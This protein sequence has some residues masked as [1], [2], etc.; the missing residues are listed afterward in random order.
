MVGYLLLSCARILVHEKR[1]QSSQQDILLLAAAFATLLPK[2]CSWL[3][4]GKAIHI[5]Y[6]LGMLFPIIYVQLSND[7]GSAISVGQM[8]FVRL[9]FLPCGLPLF[10]VAFWNAA[11]FIGSVVRF[12]VVAAPYQ[13]EAAY[14]PHTLLALEIFLFTLT[15]AVSEWFRLLA[16]SEM[17]RDALAK[18]EGLQYDALGV[19]M[20]NVCDVTLPLDEHFV[21]SSDS[22]RFTALLMRDTRRSLKGTN[23]QDYMAC[24]DDKERFRNMFA[25]KDI[26]EKPVVACLNLSLRESSGINI[27]VEVFGVRFKRIDGVPSYIL[28]IRE[29]AA[30]RWLAPLRHAEETDTK[31]KQ[32]RSTRRSV[33]SG[34][35]QA[36]MVGVSPINQLVDDSQ[37]H[38][39]DSLFDSPCTSTSSK[40]KSVARPY[41]QPT[42]RGAKLQSMTELIAVWSVIAPNKACCGFHATLAEAKNVL[43]ILLRGP[44]QPAF[45][46][47]DLLQCGTCGILSDPKGSRQ[48]TLCECDLFA[49][50]QAL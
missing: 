5:S 16:W 6:G 17:F 12:A 49:S 1:V 2:H 28:G 24:E 47:E 48:C 39:F 30:D 13:G 37:S 9:S 27:G 35:P 18:S 26:G 43:K 11:C 22:K 23:I 45:Y 21:V 4:P 7:S 8:A 14:G 15:I 3:E 41:P 31:S 44:C 25:H 50:R 29:N 33:E 34:S 40:D 46:D 42:G 36:A 10:E 20:D 19:L 32:K 38:S